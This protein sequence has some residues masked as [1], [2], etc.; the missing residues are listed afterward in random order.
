MKQYATTMGAYSRD[1]DE[2]NGG[3]SVV[4]DE[5]D[6]PRGDDWRMVGCAA[7]NGI[8]FWFWEREVKS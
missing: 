1:R 4:A 3:T 7:A 8:L 5:P 6:P 2:Q